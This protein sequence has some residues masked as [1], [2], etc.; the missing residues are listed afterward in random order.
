M[1][2]IKILPLNRFADRRDVPSAFLEKFNAIN[3]L[4]VGI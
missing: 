4:L 2:A 1:T 3:N